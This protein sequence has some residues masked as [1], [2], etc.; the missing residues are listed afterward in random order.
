VFAIGEAD[1][2]SRAQIGGE[3]QP[4]DSPLLT[5]EPR[6]IVELGT[7]D[8]IST[9]A[10]LAAAEISDA[11]VLS[12]DTADCSRIAI[13]ERF[14]QRW[15]F[16]CADDVIFAGPPFA[17]FCAE[18]NWPPVADVILVD[19]SHVYEH[20]KRE[21]ESWV[22]R[23]SRRG[24]MLFHDTNMG[25]GWFRCLD[26]KAEPGW[27]NERGVIRAIEEFVERTYDE[28]TYFTDAAGGYVIQHVP[29]SSGLTILRKRESVPL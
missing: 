9:R 25:K 2:H 11:H 6:L 26:G 20:T 23:L 4:R 15:T 10:L 7:R 17:N 24:T 19:T 12:I 27:N 16:A 13:G 3:N 14:R 5:G 1:G 18:R 28:R 8:G 21:I 22:P 29:W